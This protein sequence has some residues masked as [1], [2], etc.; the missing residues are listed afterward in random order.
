MARIANLENE[1]WLLILI[2]L[3]S[4]IL[5]RYGI[6]AFTSMYLLWSLTS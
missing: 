4:L 5:N 3:I 2:K 1:T 6:I